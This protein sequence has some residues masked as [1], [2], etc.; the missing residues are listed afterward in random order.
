MN[1]L[2]TD[3]T[4]WAEGILHDLDKSGFSGINIIEK[5][6]RDP[7]ISTR[8]S[9]HRV[10][11]WPRGARDKQR[12]MAKMSKAM[13]QV[14]PT[15]QICLVIKHG[16]MLRGDGNI[17]TKYDLR[18]DSSIGLRRFNDECRIAKTKLR[19]IL[20]TYKDGLDSTGFFTL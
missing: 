20:K 2:D 10:H 19:E 3:I 16:R 7:G 13:H 6:L 11:W 14:T 18:K 17:Y 15:G 12:R 5:I 8:G 1:K 4:E 9:R